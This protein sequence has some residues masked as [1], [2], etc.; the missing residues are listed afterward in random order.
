MSIEASTKEEVISNLY[1]IRAGLSYIADLSDKSE[2]NNAKSEQ[3]SNDK[4]TINN[5]IISL[6]KEVSKLQNFENSIEWK[7]VEARKDIDYS[8]RLIAST[9]KDLEL[10]QK[11]VPEKIHLGVKSI[12][13]WGLFL[14]GFCG[15]LALTILA[16][17]SNSQVLEDFAAI[18]VLA[19]VVF[20]ILFI[21]K[22]VG[23]VNE[24]K[25]FQ[26][27][28]KKK[29][30]D[31]IASL[32]KMLDGARKNIQSRTARIA[33]LEL[34][35]EH[36]KDDAPKRAKEKEKEILSLEKQIEDIDIEINSLS[37]ENDLNHQ[38]AREIYDGLK[39]TF[40][41]FFHPQNWKY[42]DRV[43]YYLS[44]GR[45]DTI[46]E[47]LNQLDQRLNAELIANEIRTTSGMIAQ[48]IRESR[49]DTMNAIS[50]AANSINQLMGQ[51]GIALV[52]S[53]QAISAQLDETNR[54]TAEN[55]SNARR[56][57]TAQ[58]LNNSLMRQ[59]NTSI[60]KLL[61]KCSIM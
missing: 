13:L 48:E 27:K 32:Q 25:V 39:K 41:G 38:S 33:E 55:A 17:T 4:N 7:I 37:A 35:I 16:Y 42:L 46:R 45:A 19:S 60:D 51:V 61:D 58:D 53:N 40:S 3:L 26:Y 22:T 47:A 36:E 1:S 2:I 5:Q 6:R 28:A 9:Q 56:L 30:D 18:F 57:L 21:V 20:L 59:A 8:T 29:L 23:N 10:A 44:T 50:N 34:K 24:K 15:F 11:D 12:L 54:L 43:V 49:A 31:K 14:L 52:T